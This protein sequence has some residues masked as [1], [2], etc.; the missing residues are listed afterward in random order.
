[1]CGHPYDSTAS[2]KWYVKRAAAIE[3]CC[4]LLL[5][6]GSVEEPGSVEQMKRG[7]DKVDYRDEEG[8]CKLVNISRMV[9]RGWREWNLEKVEREGWSE[10][11]VRDVFRE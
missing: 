8:R 6:L 7:T 5:G 11:M 2:Y 4:C 9:E 1:M 3:E 10:G